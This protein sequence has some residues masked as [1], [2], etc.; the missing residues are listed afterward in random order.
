MI[1]K[2]V[3]YPN[4][5]TTPWSPV[6]CT[7][8]GAWCWFTQWFPWKNHLILERWLSFFSTSYTNE[9]KYNR[10]IKRQKIMIKR[11]S[12]SK[13]QNISAQFIYFFIC[14]N[15][16]ILPMFSYSV[17][18]LCI[19]FSTSVISFLI[20]FLVC[21]LLSV[22]TDQ[23]CLKQDIVLGVASEVFL[24]LT[25][26]HM[27]FLFDSKWFRQISSF[28]HL[29][30]KLTGPICFALDVSF[31]CTVKKRKLKLFDINQMQILSTHWKY[32][33]H[34]YLYVDTTKIFNCFMA[35]LSLFL[36][37]IWKPY[38]LNF[39]QWI[40]LFSLN[41]MSFVADVSMEK[42]QLH[43]FCT[44]VNYSGQI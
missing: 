34:I 32:F 18:F 37:K 4:Q 17:F 20:F 5:S 11:R 40:C 2:F 13:T 26:G 12:N 14:Q 42:A 38:Y 39:L 16:Y 19:I 36:F 33:E 7:R 1:L 22:R 24:S 25:Q 3:S 44:L 43:L 30:Q 27:F 15:I 41:Y 10:E 6:I 23:V 29:Y 35:S 9:K 21:I 31:L 8:N 28:S